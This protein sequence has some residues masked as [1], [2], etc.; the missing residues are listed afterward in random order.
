[1]GEDLELAPDGDDVC[2]R[3]KKLCHQLLARPDRHESTHED[4]ELTVVHTVA[5]GD[6]AHVQHDLFSFVSK[7]RQALGSAVASIAVPFIRTHLLSFFN[8]GRR[9]S[10]CSLVTLRS[11]ADTAAKRVRLAKR[12]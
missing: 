9:T 11:E 7:V 12:M 3:G 4:D 1:M 10:P 8:P 2:L 5:E 6:L